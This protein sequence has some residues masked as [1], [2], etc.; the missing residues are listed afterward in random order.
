MV[1]KVRIEDLNI[2]LRAFRCLKRA[3]LAFVADVETMTDEQLLE[4]RNFGLKSLQDLRQ[5]LEENQDAL[6]LLQ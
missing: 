2:G 6:P 3:G 5:A 1:G 4:I